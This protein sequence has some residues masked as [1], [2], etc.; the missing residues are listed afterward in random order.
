MASNSLCCGQLD[1][2]VYVDKPTGA[3]MP[4]A[5]YF[6]ADPKCKKVTSTAYMAVKPRK[7][8]CFMEC[9]SPAESDYRLCCTECL[10]IV[11]PDHLCKCRNCETSNDLNTSFC[12]H[13]GAKYIPDLHS[14]AGG[15]QSSSANMQSSNVLNVSLSPSSFEQP[16]GQTMYAPTASPV[17]GAPPQYANMPPYGAAPP[18]Y[19]NAPPPYPYY[20]GY[21]PAYPHP[22]GPGG[23]QMNNNGPNNH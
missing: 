6:C 3:I 8:F 13:C 23:Q 22:P 20:N 2:V 16:K 19:G 15:N 11:N 17:I 9:C 18:Q 21:P 7:F 14:G 5:K 4:P 12:M 10:H 1:E